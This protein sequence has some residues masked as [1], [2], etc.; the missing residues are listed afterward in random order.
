MGG[1][2]ELAHIN[3]FG[4]AEPLAVLG[5]VASALFKLD[6]MP[7]DPPISLNQDAIDRNHGLPMA[8]GKQVA[9]LGLEFCIVCAG[10]FI[11]GMITPWGVLLIKKCLFVPSN[12]RQYHK[13]SWYITW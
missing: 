13:A 8:P 9:D 7:A 10:G 2:I 6:N 12:L 1:K 5:P 4:T 11:L 3:E